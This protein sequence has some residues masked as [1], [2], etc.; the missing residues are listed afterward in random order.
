VQFPAVGVGAA[1]QRHT[2][3]CS[4]VGVFLFDLRR[5]RVGTVAA[6]HDIAQ[7]CGWMQHDVQRLRVRLD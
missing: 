5:C 1:L 3:S 4:L 6:L 7:L 2:A